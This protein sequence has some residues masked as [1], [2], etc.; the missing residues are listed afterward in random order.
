MSSYPAP[1]S[2]HLGEALWFRG[3]QQKFA[4]DVAGVDVSLAH[5]HDTVTILE[6]QCQSQQS[7]ERMIDFILSKKISYITCI[8]S[9][10]N[11]AKVTVDNRKVW[12]HITIAVRNFDSTCVMAALE[13]T[14]TDWVCDHIG[15]PILMLPIKCEAVF[16]R[17]VLSTFALGTGDYGFTL[18]G[19]I[20]LTPAGV[21]A[22]MRVL[23]FAQTPISLTGYPSQDGR[24]LRPR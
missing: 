20:Y 17:H 6:F 15:V 18:L 1:S 5:H 10:S 3:W 23:H 2:E 21:R 4:M 11:I 8:K 9:L 24:R 16:I 22:A 14:S 12:E 7:A 13:K 19:D